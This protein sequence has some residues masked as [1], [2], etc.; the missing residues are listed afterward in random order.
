MRFDEKRSKQNYDGTSASSQAA[1]FRAPGIVGKAAA[2]IGGAI[3]LL[4]TLA[5]SILFFAVLIVAGVLVGGYLWWKTRELRK[6][7]RTQLS[8]GETLQGEIIEGEIIEGE[9]IVEDTPERD[10]RSGTSPRDL[11]LK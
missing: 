3:L 8:S 6:Q 4:S 10:T 5:L 2:V 7:I 1:P 9:I 11:R